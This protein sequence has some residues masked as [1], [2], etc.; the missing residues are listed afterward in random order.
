MSKRKQHQ[1]KRAKQQIPSPQKNRPHLRRW[2][3]LGT[4]VSVVSVGIVLMRSQSNPFVMTTAINLFVIIGLLV[5]SIQTIYSIWPL[6]RSSRPSVWQ[7]YLNERPRLMQGINFTCIGMSVLLLTTA[8]FVPLPS[9]PPPPSQTLLMIWY[10]KPDFAGNFHRYFAPNGPCDADGYRVSSLPNLG[11][12][13]QVSSWQ[14]F[15]HCDWIRAYTGPSGTG[16]CFLFHGQTSQI[17]DTLAHRIQSFRLSS[18]KQPCF[19]ATT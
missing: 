12:T 10:D 5:A 4:V 14:V 2:L 19:P 17:S 3:L 9:E 8:V 11:W 16:E 15:S 6:S 1:T 13:S 7:T 18:V